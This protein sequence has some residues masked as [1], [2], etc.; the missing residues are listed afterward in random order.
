M[1]VILVG[2]GSFGLGWYRSLKAYSIP[3]QVV[4][5]DRN[6][7]VRSLIDSN[8][9][10]YPDLLTA[11]DQE[12]PDFLINLTPPRVHTSVNHLAF[13]RRIPV[14]C[15]KPIAEDFSEAQVVVTRAIQEQIP[16]MIAENYRRAPVFRMAQRLIKEKAVGELSAVFVQFFK[17]AY[18]EKEYLLQMKEPLLVDV[19]VHHLDLVRYLTGQEGK[20][21]FAKS[22]NPLGSQYPGNAAVNIC[23]EMQNGLIVNYAG[24]LAGRGQETAWPGV[25]RIEGTKG[26]MTVAENIQLTRTDHEETIRDFGGVDDRSCLDEFLSALSE[27]REPETSGVDYLQTQKLVH[28]SIESIRFGHPVDID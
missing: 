2:I 20:R 4:V 3:L 16:F 23:L 13:D 19:T 11:L 9:L 14:L 8:D 10:F 12:R 1:K 22:F 28:F 18:F 5:V 17:E 15:E 27:A 25:W 21:I 7:A 6:P 24:S 26:V